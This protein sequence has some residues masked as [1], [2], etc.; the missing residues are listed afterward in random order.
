[1]LKRIAVNPWPW[2]VRYGFNQAEHLENQSRMLICS[3]QAAVDRDGKPKFLGDM[4]GQVVLAFEN[5]DAVLEAGNMSLA[6]VVK[7]VLYTTDI[8]ALIS[9]FGVIGSLMKAANIAPAQTMVQVGRLF[10]PDLLFEVEA[11][12]IA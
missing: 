10:S 1:M 9:E 7:L 4:R 3:G 2:S 11:I 12:A 5:L 6:N 8:D